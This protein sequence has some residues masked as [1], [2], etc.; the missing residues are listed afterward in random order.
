MSIVRTPPSRAA[1]GTSVMSIERTPELGTK[2]VTLTVKLPAMKSSGADSLG[3]GLRE[4]YRRG[5]F[6][7]VALVCAERHFQAH[8]IV[9]AAK[10][11]VLK[12]SLA[13]SGVGGG[14]A[15]G[16]GKQEIRLVEIANPEAVNFMLDYMY[17]MDASVW[18][19]YNPR[20]QEINKDVLRLAQMFRLPGLTER[21]MHWL[22]K[23]LNTGNVVERLTICEDFGLQVL[24]EKILEQLTYNKKALAEVANSP[25]IM[26]YPKLMQ[27]LLQ[28]AASVPEDSGPQPKKRVRKA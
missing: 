11:P 23:D 2:P 4:L 7:D 14:Q 8:R 27:A 1:L 12:E 24:S 21:A 17:Q 22:A 19:D 26:T 25:Q 13:G 6:T 18:E 3:E 16:G 20:T 9:L 5:E 28:K 10:S 15:E